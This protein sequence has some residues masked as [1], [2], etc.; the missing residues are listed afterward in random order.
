MS[1]TNCPHCTAPVPPAFASMP[2][3]TICGGDLS[4]AAPSSP[5]WSSIDIKTDNTR[6]CHKC[7]D[8]IKS[9]LAMECPT[10]GVDLA[11]AG[12]AIDDID[13]EKA[14]FEEIVKSSNKKA[15]PAKAQ[16]IEES[17]KQELPKPS[18]KSNTSSSEVKPYSETKK[19]VS[20]QKQ[21]NDE[22]TSLR[23]KKKAKEGFFSKL[24]R[25]LGLKKD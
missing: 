14:D 22:S 1:V 7:G 16:V 8:K 13:K 18:L 19:E 3:C 17:P 9:I 23:N 24:L 12:K 11:P 25:M 15:E 5:V 10:C 6:T 4:A 21:K 20:K 2:V